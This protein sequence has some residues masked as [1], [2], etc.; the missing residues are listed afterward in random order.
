MKRYVQKGSVPSNAK[1]IHVDRSPSLTKVIS[2]L[3]HYSNNVIAETIVKTIGAE[4]SGEPGTFEAGLSESRTF[5]ESEVGL[6][7][8]EYIFEN[9][10]GLNDVNR[11]TSAQVIQLLEYMEDEFDAGVE[12][13]RSLAVAGTQGTIRLRMRHGVA[14]RRLRAKTGTLRGVSALSGYVADPANNQVAFAILM[15]GYQRPVHV[16]DIWKI[17][18]RIGEALASWGESYQPEE[19][20]SLDPVMAESAEAALEPSKGGAP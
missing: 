16:Y 6:A 13:K 1:L 20:S 12:F 15:T 5:L 11:M 9:G 8:G 17:Q 3:N 10:S 18:N 19:L 7:P 2:D 4:L 14:E